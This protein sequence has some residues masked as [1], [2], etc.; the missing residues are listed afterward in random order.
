LVSDSSFVGSDT[1]AT[2]YIISHAISHVE[3]SEG[4]FDLIFCGEQAIDGDTGQVGPEVAEHLGYPQVTRSLEAKVSGNT[5][6]IRKQL[7]E[8]IALVSVHT[9]CLIAFTKAPWDVRQ[10]TIKRK[11]AANRAKINI[12]TA[13]ELTKL[14]LLAIGIEGSCTKVQTTFLPHP[15]KQCTMIPEESIHDLVCKLIHTLKKQPT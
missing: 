6:V 7:E 1:L 4:K 13:A 8:G 3:K 2:S 15:Q 5:A 10:P 14:D 11:I 9:P 12:I